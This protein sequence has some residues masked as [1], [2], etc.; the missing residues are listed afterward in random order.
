MSGSLKTAAVSATV[1]IALVLLGCSFYVSS[2][3]A[4]CSLH[5]VALS[6]QFNDG[7]LFYQNGSPQWKELNESSVVD[8]RN[9]YVRFA[10]VVEE[11]FQ[12]DRAGVVIIKT[13]RTRLQNR[14][15]QGENS[16][17][18]LARPEQSAVEAKRCGTPKR[19]SSRTV[20]AHSYER[21]HDVGETVPDQQTLDDFHFSY[22][23]R[24]GPCRSTS[25]NDQ[26]SYVPWDPR[27][28]RGQFS[29]NTSVV[30]HGTYFQPFVLLGVS[31]AV[32]SAERLIQA[33]VETLRYR[34]EKGTPT[35]M[36]F[37]HTVNGPGAF[38]R[39]NDLE[40]IGRPN[41]FLR[42]NEIRVTLSPE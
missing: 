16:D 11:T 24:R 35:C 5:G 19:F 28:N 29:F 25:N 20:S 36:I 3:K 7:K 32:A 12:D 10:Y 15:S 13:G 40:S 18:R 23:S 39:V 17:V 4:N 22:Q 8:L 6:G 30:D 31:T 37:G 26:D 34:T 21:Y 1:Q 33:R 38:L 14:P 27:T 9:H 41:R 42:S 2:A